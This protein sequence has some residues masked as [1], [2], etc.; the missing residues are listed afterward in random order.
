[1]P[2]GVKTWRT[3][4]RRGLRIWVSNSGDSYLDMWKNAV[5][6]ER[7]NADFR[8]IVENSG[9]DDDDDDDSS[10]DLAKKTEEFNRILEVSREERDRAQ[11]M[12]VID[13][14]AAAIAAARAIINE[15]ESTADMGSG[16][17]GVGS[18]GGIVTPQ[19]G[20][21]WIYYQ[22]ACCKFVVLC[23][24]DFRFCEMKLKHC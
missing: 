3:T 11:R 22:S 17:S 21:I 10:E 1:M 16:E 14:A 13:R 20:K 18:G 12:Q 5:E 24:L 4:R 23:Y 8:K 9:G 19:E 6:S 2:V 15:S 7:K